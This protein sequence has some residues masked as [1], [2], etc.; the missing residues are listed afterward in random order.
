MQ[1]VQNTI[2]PEYGFEDNEF[3]EDFIKYYNK[4]YA[5]EYGPVPEGVL[6]D[7]TQFKEWTETLKGPM[8]TQYLEKKDS[9]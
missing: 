2:N 5:A 6:E 4:F 1:F 8:K 9:H 7:E 3:K